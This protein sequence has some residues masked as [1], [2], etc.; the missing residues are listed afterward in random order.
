M[1]SLD[2]FAKS[3][4]DLFDGKGTVDDSIELLRSS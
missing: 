1:S 2:G 3:S 4:G